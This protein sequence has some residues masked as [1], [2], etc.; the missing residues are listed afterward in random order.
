MFVVLSCFGLYSRHLFH[1]LYG[2]EFLD[3]DIGLAGVVN[4][5]RYIASKETVFGGDVDVSH[6]EL[7]LLRDDVGDV[8]HNADV[9]IAHD[10]QGDG[11]FRRTLS[12]PACLDDAVAE[13]A[14]QL[15]C[16][17]TIGAVYLDFPLRLI[18][19][20]IFIRWFD[21]PD[22]NCCR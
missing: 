9:V 15:L 20:T 11:V 19:V 13:T 10:A 8:A 6:D 17:G 12:A 5:H 22:I 16:V 1:A 7:V 14:A 21:C 3:Q 4:H 2:S 18:P